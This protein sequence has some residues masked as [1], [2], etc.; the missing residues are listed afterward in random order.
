MCKHI[1]LLG[2]A[3]RKKTEQKEADRKTMTLLRI[4]D[5]WPT[6]NKTDQPTQN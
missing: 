3:A 6:D 2:N 4:E 5:D 1:L